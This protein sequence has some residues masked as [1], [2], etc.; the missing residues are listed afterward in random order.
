MQKM[1]N[2]IDI[3]TQKKL[4]EYYKIYNVIKK[5]IAYHKPIFNE[6]F[7]EEDPFNT[8]ENTYIVTMP[9]IIIPKIIKVLKLLHYKN[10]TYLS[11]DEKIIT[12]LPYKSYAYYKEIN[13]ENGNTQFVFC[14][15]I[16][17]KC[18][19]IILSPHFTLE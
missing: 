14:L 3:E 13:S 11:N 17:K 15:E 7:K 19:G 10:K 16:D 1:S 18:K 8:T 2:E 9:Y 6:S 4:K 5:Y 12:G